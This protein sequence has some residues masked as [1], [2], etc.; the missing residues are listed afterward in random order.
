MLQP[1]NTVMGS[2][3]QMWTVERL[4]GSGTCC[5]VYQATVQGEE[6]KVAIKIFNEGP[7]YEA[8]FHR[9][10]LLLK[11]LH[12][13][14]PCRQLVSAITDTQ[15]SNHWCLIQELLDV[16]VR[17]IL[18]KNQ[19]DGLSVHLIQNLACDI[20][21][22]LCCLHK[23]GFVHADI[24]PRNLLWSAQDGC[25]KIIDFSLTFHVEDKRLGR[26]QSTGY[27]APEAERW[28]KSTVLSSGDNDCPLPS[29]SADIWSVGCV[30]VEMFTA[31]KLLTKDM[32]ESFN[33]SDSEGSLALPRILAKL[34]VTRDQDSS[35]QNAFTLIHEL[36]QLIIS[37]LQ[38]D[39]SKR[40][41]AEDCL[42]H[43][44]FQQQTVPKYVDFLLLPS[45]VL[46]FLNL[47]DP[48]KVLDESE[49]V[50]VQEDMMEECG[51]YGC[52]KKCV[53]GQEGQGLGKV[54]VEFAFTHQAVTAFECLCRKTFDGHTV[55]ITYFPA[56][57]FHD[58]PPM[59][60][61]SETR[62]PTNSD[63]TTTVEQAEEDTYCP[64]SCEGGRRL[65]QEDSPLS[66][67]LIM[68]PGCGRLLVKFV[69]TPLEPRLPH[70]ITRRLLPRVH[71]QIP[72][73]MDEWKRGQDR[74]VWK[75]LVTDL[76]VGGG[77]V[78]VV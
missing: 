54:F 57:D 40:P 15:H 64:N 34:I 44:F 30:L 55:L 63:P 68:L 8:A 29:T 23:A 32:Q 65:L 41:S 17:Q 11:M 33:R 75:S 37:M 51:K 77:C 61:R 12:H 1:G 28:N 26:L 78:M 21:S 13:I 71:H 9:E 48:E 69:R 70:N 18:L 4:L 76:H 50:A 53:V 31:S 14:M 2:A 24:K 49:L 19:G 27:R 20:L 3:G 59:A 56:G 22:G 47:I 25:M 72:T 6:R 74:E 52:L 5:H 38:T 43:T 16:D 10:K 35:T 67:W 46:R 7:K 73:T 36:Q 45:C 60:H 39:V 62:S 58:G 42:N 66:S